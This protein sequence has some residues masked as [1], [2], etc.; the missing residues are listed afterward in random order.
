MC[1]TWAIHYSK[2]WKKPR[3]PCRIANRG[4]WA[5]TS[6]AQSEEKYLLELWDKDVC[7]NCGKDIPEGTRVGSG[8]KREGGFCT[9]DCY[10]DITD[11]SWP[12]ELQRISDVFRRHLES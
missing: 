1:S 11:W 10:T 3:S 2:L 7:P 8:K 5:W 4:T 12:S 9:L 6:M